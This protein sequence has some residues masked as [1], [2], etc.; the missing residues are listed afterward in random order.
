VEAKEKSHQSD[1]GFKKAGW[2]IAIEH[3]AAAGGS[4][5]GGQVES[6]YRNVRG[7]W[8]KWKAFERAAGSGWTKLDD[9]SLIIDR[10]V[11]EQFFQTYPE[12][13]RLNFSVTVWQRGIMRLTKAPFD[14]HLLPHQIK[15]VC[16]CPIESSK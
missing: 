4:S 5:G 12:F 1:N 15:N 2:K 16:C 8:D 10:E 9:G 6:K 3:V 14:L 11:E 13:K 7:I